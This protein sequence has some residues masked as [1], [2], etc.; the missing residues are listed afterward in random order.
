[1]AAVD[2]AALERLLSLKTSAFLCEPAGRGGPKRFLAGLRH[3]AG[4]PASAPSLALL[5]KLA[6]A[7]A[8][9]AEPLYAR[10]D[11]LRL[12]ADTRSDAAGV[13]LFPVSEWPER[14]EM[15]REDW[16]HLTPDEDPEG[17]LRG[18]AIGE[19]PQSG[20]HLVWVMEGPCAGQIFYL[21]HSDWPE[22]PF[23]ADFAEL[24][25][26]LTRDPVKLIEALGHYARYADGR[27]ETQWIPIEFREDAP[28]AHGEVPPRAASRPKSGPGRTAA[29]RPQAG[30]RR[31]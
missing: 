25:P 4:P 10:H 28:D 11:G 12:F 3:E 14:T 17:L 31:K 24:L 29:K 20:N 8:P 5:R 13:A 26:R 23:A 9:D 16:A 22:G 1:V 30:R 27:T 15:M 21:E 18:L 2:L 7:R 19:A 6:G